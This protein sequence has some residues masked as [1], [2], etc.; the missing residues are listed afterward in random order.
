MVVVSKNRRTPA[1]TKARICAS[2]FGPGLWELSPRGHWP[3]LAVLFSWGWLQAVR[4]L[5]QT[6]REAAADSCGNLMWSSCL[7]FYIGCRFCAVPLRRFA[8]D[9]VMW[10]HIGFRVGLFVRG[11]KILR[12]D[13]VIV[14]LEFIGLP[15]WWL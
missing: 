7:F 12:I 5:M 15:N 2:R 11:M 8:R 13:N 9:G 6:A 3:I 10:E 14:M 4:G 1:S